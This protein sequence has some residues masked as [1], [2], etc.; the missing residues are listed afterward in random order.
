MFLV[1]FCVRFSFTLLFFLSHSCNQIK[2]AVFALTHSR[3]RMM[4]FMFQRFSIVHVKFHHFQ[5]WLYC[6]VQ[7]T[8]A[9]LII[10]QNI[11]LLH[12]QTLC[13]PFL[14]LCL[15]QSIFPP[16]Y[17][18]YVFNFQ[19]ISAKQF[20]I[21]WCLQMELLWIARLSYIFI[22]WNEKEGKIDKQQS[23]LCEC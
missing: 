17:I 9:C 13:F 20:Q 22:P 16:A 2:L 1:I 12:R 15:S 4:K 3:H 6:S 5:S 14:S 11:V 8:H 10:T 23:V 7:Y 21:T 18:D 19:T